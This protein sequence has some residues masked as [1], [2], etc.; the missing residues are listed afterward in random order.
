MAS[1]DMLVLFSPML[2]SQAINPES[3]FQ[4]LE[5]R[6]WGWENE[7]LY[8]PKST[9]WVEGTK[10]QSTPLG[11]LLNMRERMTVALASLRAN[12]PGHLSTEQHQDWVSD[13]E[14]L[15]NTIEELLEI[16]TVE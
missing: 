9:F 10:G 12:Q 6:G 2:N 1:L 7:R 4:A 11:V 8:A 5:A 13:M 16:Q 3:L 15:V 14:S